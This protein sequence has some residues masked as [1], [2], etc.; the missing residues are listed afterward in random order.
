MIEEVILFQLDQVSKQAKLYSQREFDR[1]GLDI[2]VEQW[3]LL[4]IIEESDGLSQK[5]LADKSLRDPASITR[6][7]DLLEKKE[8]IERRPIEGNRRQ[9]D[10]VLSDEGRGFV[11]SH[12]PIIQEYRSQSIKGLSKQD[13]ETLKSVLQRIKENMT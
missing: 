7:L 6:T 12:L 5:E 8:L 11:L 13:L 2:T 3:I 1:L 4:K 10:I 9:Y